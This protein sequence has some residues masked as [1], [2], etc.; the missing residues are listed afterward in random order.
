MKVL[1]NILFLLAFMSFISCFDE[2]NKQILPIKLEVPSNE[3]FLIDRSN[4]IGFEIFKQNIINKGCDENI[5]ISP[6]GVALSV[7]YLMQ[8]T[9]VNLQGNFRELLG[10]GILGDSLIRDGFFNLYKKY[11]E[12]DQHTQFTETANFAFNKDLN[13][14]PGFVQFVRSQPNLK[15]TTT[16][17]EG[18]VPDPTTRIE[19]PKSNSFQLINT[20]TFNTRCRFQKNHDKLPFYYNPQQSELVEMV[21]SEAMHLYYGDASLKS[22]EIPLGRGNFNIILVLPKGNQSVDDLAR[23]INLRLFKRIIEKSSLENI[24]VFFPKLHFSSIE[25]HAGILSKGILAPCFSSKQADFNG[26]VASNDIVLSDFEQMIDFGIRAYPDEAL[27]KF[28][29]DL[30]KDTGKSTL[31]IDRPFLFIVYEKLSEGILF[32]G[33]ISNP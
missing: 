29:P 16:G 14:A 1:A 18:F 4:Q 22:V 28:P 8:G 21:S 5:L 19:T 30:H 23:S 9:G 7:C 13:F 12:I 17:Q 27:D 2:P 3:K 6:F 26:I 33:K 24:E 15:L 20:I 11:S 25:S 10:A 32:I 31:F